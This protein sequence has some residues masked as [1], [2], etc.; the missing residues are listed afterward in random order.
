ME[1]VVLVLERARARSEMERW[2]FKVK[3]NRIHAFVTICDTS[4]ACCIAACCIVHCIATSR[5]IIY[6]IAFIGN[7]KQAF[8]HLPTSTYLTIQ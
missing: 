4:L 6:Y 8:A 3:E 1:E 7:V 2:R 5:S